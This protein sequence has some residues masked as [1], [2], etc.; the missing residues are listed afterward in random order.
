MLDKIALGS[1][2]ALGVIGLGL[3]IAYNAAREATVAVG[4]RVAGFLF[5][6][7]SA[8]S[9]AVDGLGAVRRAVWGLIKESAAEHL[10]LLR[11][12]AISGALA[13]KIIAVLGWALPEW[14]RNHLVEILMLLGAAAMFA[15]TVHGRIHA[16][17]P[18]VTPREQEGAMGPGAA[19][20]LATKA[21]S[22][23][24]SFA[25]LSDDDLRGIMRGVRAELRDR[26]P[27]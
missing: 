6:S 19:A 12:R 7:C 10:P 9:R 27:A 20:E 23:V 25:A 15:R 16:R 2:V 1:I 22:P 3:F 5:G 17:G 18:I 13:L 8:L 26:A 4:R 24:H 21:V 14:A 11:S